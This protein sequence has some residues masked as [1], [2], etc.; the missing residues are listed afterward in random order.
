VK[1]SGIQTS[2][3]VAFEDAPR[4]GNSKPAGITPTTVNGWRSS[5]IVAPSAGRPAKWRVARPWLMMA[6]LDPL[7]SSSARNVRPSAASTPRT[8]NS[9]EVIVAASTC[10]GS[11]PPDSSTVVVRYA[12]RFENDC[13]YCRRSM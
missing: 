12:P 3:G 6:T 4:R 10:S 13:W 8:S 11:P 1:T 7:W 5:A 2:A 9:D